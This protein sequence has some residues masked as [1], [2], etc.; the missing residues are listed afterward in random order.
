MNH[1]ALNREDGSHLSQEYLHL[2]DKCGHPSSINKKPRYDIRSPLIKTLDWSAE[3]LDREC[4]ST[5]GLCI[6][7][8]KT[9]VASET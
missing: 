8:N 7:F 2:V 4:N 6:R 3:T 5:T 1:H 9:S